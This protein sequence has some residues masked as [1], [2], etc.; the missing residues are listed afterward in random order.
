MDCKFLTDEG[1]FNFR[2]AGVFVRGGLLLAMKERNIDHYYLP[3]GRVRMNETM[4]EALR[5]ETDE[6][7]GVTARVIRPLWLCESFFQLG[8]R[9][10]HEIAM[11]YLA[12]LDW[13]R[14]PALEGEFTLADS[15]GTE[16]IY[17]WLTEDEVRS[18]RIYP[19]PMQEC[20]PDLPESFTFYSDTRDRR[21]L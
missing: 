12:G 7:L 6:E 17:R 18:S 4:E 5:R 13:D 9:P 15:D 1:L 10:V 16:H 14:L 21:N 11:Y 19:V 8:G 2:V 20:W 3:G